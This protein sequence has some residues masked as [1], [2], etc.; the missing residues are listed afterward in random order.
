MACPFRTEVR[1]SL[2]TFNL[3]LILFTSKT[4]AFSN[5]K[6]SELFLA[7]SRFRQVIFLERL[8]TKYKYTYFYVIKIQLGFIP[9]LMTINL[10]V[11]A[12]VSSR[13]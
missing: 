13:I 10:K 1:L 4:V 11:N 8:P 2:S 3:F 6:N 12:T 9:L 7:Y 5:F